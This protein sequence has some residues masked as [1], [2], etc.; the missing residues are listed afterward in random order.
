MPNLGAVIAPNSQLVIAGGGL[1]V[2]HTTT[3]SITGGTNLSQAGVT[4]GSINP[5]TG[6]VSLTFKNDKG[7]KVKAAGAA[8]DNSG[9]AGGYFIGSTNDGSFVLHP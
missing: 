2:P 5:K 7:A 4:I 6:A 3:V 8:L 1:A 9:S